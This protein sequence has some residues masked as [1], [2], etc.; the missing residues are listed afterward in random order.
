MRQ[1][2]LGA[3]AL[4]GALASPALAA[5]PITAS[6]G[7]FSNIGLIYQNNGSDP[8]L[9]VI[10]DGEIHFKFRGTSDNGL[11]F[12]GRVELEAFGTGDQI[13]EYW[14]RVSGPWG[15]ILIGTDD[16]AADKFSTGVFETPSHLI[17]YMNSD[18]G[19]FDPSTEGDVPVIRYTTP[20]FYG[21][22]ASADWAPDSTADPGN[23]QITFGN[24]Q[25]RYS[26]GAGWEGEFSGVDIEIGGG[27][28]DY[29][30]GR[31]SWTLGGVLGYQGVA[32]GV[33]FDEDG[34]EDDFSSLAVGLRYA[35]GPWTFAG[36]W[37]MA[38]DGPDYNSWA[39]WVTYALAP[40]ATLA[41]GYE[42]NDDAARTG[43]Q[44]TTVASYLNLRF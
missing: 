7:G 10:A 12:D 30:N 40:G 28:V 2:L 35:T 3:T 22:R 23:Q 17:G 18:Q 26:V 31:E 41:L 37:S 4:L 11:T 33:Y 43:G 21:F 27:F 6:V 32:L 25:Q 39:V 16:T 44:D 9:G 8:E 36:G 20:S 19:I 29:E 13:D 38:M 34:L 24:S 5:D 14:A 15:A 1:Q 42:G